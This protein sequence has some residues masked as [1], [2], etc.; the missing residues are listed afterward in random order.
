[1]IA[2]FKAGMFF[3]FAAGAL[4]ALSRA[5]HRPGFSIGGVAWDYVLVPAGVGALCMI[6]CGLGMLAGLAASVGAL[7]LSFK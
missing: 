7:V 1:M 4:A 5:L 3:S 2:L 6:P